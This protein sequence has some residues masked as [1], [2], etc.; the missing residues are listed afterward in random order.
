MEKQVLDNPAKNQEKQYQYLIVIVALMVT[1]YLTSNI[2]AVKLIDIYGITWFDAGTIVFP[3][4]YML[5]DV[6]TEM[7]GY[8]TAK[9]V[10]YLTFMCNVFMTV[11]TYIGVFFDSPDY[12]QEVK[13]AYAVIFS[14]TPRILIASLLAFLIGEIT[15]AKVMAEVK[16]KTKGKY[17]FVRTILSSAVG[18]VFDTAVFVVIAFVGTSPFEDICGMILVQYFIKLLLEAVFT[19]PIVYIVV[20]FLKK[21]IQEME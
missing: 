2:M 8:K 18:Y 16:K 12:M 7:W 20:G 4:A 15:N 21:R 10:I 1:S 9:K 13:D 6:L 19:T 3:I 11:A 17:L 5:G 14:Y